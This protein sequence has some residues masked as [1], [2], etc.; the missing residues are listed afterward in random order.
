[1]YIDI[2]LDS[3]HT[4]NFF[5][6]CVYT[7]LQ[8]LYAWLVGWWIVSSFLFLGILCRVDLSL[9]KHHLLS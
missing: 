9:N 3:K 8:W 2:C 7:V 4:K 1:M 5:F 6:M